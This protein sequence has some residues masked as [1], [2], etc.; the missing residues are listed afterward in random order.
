MKIR[1]LIIGVLVLGLASADAAEQGASPDR[2]ALRRAQQTIARLQSEKS[3]AEKRAAEASAKLEAAAKAQETLTG[4]TA[5]TRSM[6]AVV[7]KESIRLRTELAELKE[8][9]ARGESQHTGAA[10][11]LQQCRESVARLEETAVKVEQQHAVQANAA[12][13]R[14]KAESAAVQSCHAANKQLHGLMVKLIGQYE[15]DAGRRI[16]PVFGLGLI[17]IEKAAQDFRDRADELKIPQRA[18]P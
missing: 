3:E 14:L 15:R 10:R 13:S 1:Y 11:D 5:R 16:E 6:L 12:Q 18:M 2:A 7:E 8:R 17:D 4:R 9:L